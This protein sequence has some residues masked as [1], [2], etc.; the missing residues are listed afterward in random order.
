MRMRL[1]SLSRVAFATALLLSVGT[2]PAMAQT[3]GIPLGNAPGIT[4]WYRF[5]FDLFDFPPV[6]S[7]GTDGDGFGGETGGFSF[8]VADG[9]R[10]RFRVTGAEQG[11]FSFLVSGLPASFTTD[12]PLYVADDQA[13]SGSEAWADPRYSQGVSAFF[14]AGSYTV[15]L[16]LFETHPDAA[17]LTGAFGF[18]SLELERLTAP[19]PGDPTPV[20]EPASTLLVVGGVCALLVTARRRA[21]GRAR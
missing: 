21:A 7:Y 18:V 3:F 5:N 11:G 9:L 8:T 4:E 20:P 12:A 17:G 10:A 1:R 19:G 13:L 2:R 14:G 6:F 16:D 15:T